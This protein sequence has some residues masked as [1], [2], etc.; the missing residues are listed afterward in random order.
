MKKWY[1]QPYFNRRT[2]ILEN[3]DKLNLN[4]DET[5]LLLLIDLCKSNRKAVTYDYLTEKL[6]MS[7]KDIDKIVAALVEKQYLKLST[8]AKGLVFDIDNIFEYDVNEFAIN[9]NKDI[10]DTVGDIFGKPLNSSELQKT[11]DLINEYGEQAFIHALRIAEANKKYK[12]SYIEGI[13]RNEK[14]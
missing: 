12:L 14:K 10:Y 8:S 3:F 2:W 6:Q 5:L 11:S 1:K 13:L 4:S 7:V 9:D